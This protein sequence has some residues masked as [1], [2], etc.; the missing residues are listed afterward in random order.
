MK[1]PGV[2]I[3]VRGVFPEGQCP[4][5]DL[6]HLFIP[7]IIQ[8]IFFECPLCASTVQ[9]AGN[10]E[11]CRTK[12]PRMI[13]EAMNEQDTWRKIERG[14]GDLTEKMTFK[15]K[16]KGERERERGHY[17][18]ERMFQKERMVREKALGQGKHVYL[19]AQSKFLMGNQDIFFHIQEPL[20]LL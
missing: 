20:P 10:T 7:L 12:T 15:Q 2:V 11:I 18:G 3:K 19:R 13:S 9:G 16:H 5:P 17:L 14:N 1:S 8:Q 6:V 4:F